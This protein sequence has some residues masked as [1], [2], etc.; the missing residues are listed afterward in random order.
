[1]ARL[2]SKDYHEKS[3]SWYFNH[4]VIPLENGDLEYW[5]SIDEKGYYHIHFVA[6]PDKKEF[7]NTQ[8]DVVYDPESQRIISHHCQECKDDESCRHYLSVLRYAYMNLRTDI[9]E[10][11]AVE[12]CD[13]TALRGKEKWLEV[14]SKAVLEIEGIYSPDT[15][16]V[17]FYHDSYEPLNISLL[18]RIQA[19]IDIEGITEQE[20]QELVSQLDIFSETEQALFKFLNEHKA[21][22]SS[23][24]KYW[25]LYKK[26]FISAL[27]FLQ[28]L[29]GKVKV[30]ETDE[31][32]KFSSE[33]YPLSLRIEPAGK[34]NYR[35]Y[36][37]IID[38]LSAVYPGYPTWLF[39]RNVVRPVYLPLS[40]ESINLLFN[41]ELLISAK[42]LIYWSTVV[43]KQLHK[44]GI[45]LDFDP[46]IELPEIIRT[47][48]RIK[49][50]VFPQGDNYI[51]EGKLVYLSPYLEESHKLEIPLSTIRFQ[52]PLIRSDYISDEENGNAWFYIPP[53]IFD[54]AKELY[55]KLPEANMSRLEQYSQLIYEGEKG[56]DKLRKS[57]FDLESPDWDLEIAAELRGDF[58]QKVD[59][60][61]EIKAKR[62]E[63]INWFSYEVSYYY[64]D[65]RFT[66]EELN[67]F[68]RSKEEF[69]HTKDGR[70]LY[71]VNPE[72]F[73]ESARLIKHS[74]RL[75]DNVYRAS[76]IELPYYHRYMREN[77]AFRML[78]DDFLTQL[79]IDL[80][81]GHMEHTEPLPLY[82]Q[83]VMRGYQKT[84]YAWIKM[85]E[86][87]HL[88]G[89]LADE[90]GLGKTIQALA[91][92]QNAP[93]NTQSLVVCP[94]TLL[95]NWAAEIDKFHINIPYLIVEGDK[96]TRI[97]LLQNPNVKLFIISYTVVLNDIDILKDKK[98]HWIILDEAQNIKNVNAKRTSAIKK[99]SAEHRL[100][101]TGTPVENNLTELWSIY[102]FLM[103]GYLGTLKRFKKE[104]IDDTENGPTRL[105]RTVAPFLLRRVKKEVLL[106]LPDKQEQVSWC[107]L[108]PVQEK[109]YLQMID[110]V[111]KKLLHGPEAAQLNF[112]NVLAALTKLRQICNHP[113]LADPDI[114]PKPEASAKLELLIELVEDAM[115]SGHKILVFSQ[116]VQMLKIIRQIFNDMNIKYAYM[117][118]RSKNRLKEVQRFENDPELQLFLI[119]LKTGGTGLNLTAADTVILYD[120]WW[121]PMVENQAIDRTHRIGQT[122]KVQVYRLI[123][124]GTVEEK[125]M[126]LQ[127]HK[128]QLFD[129]VV[130]DNKKLL[131]SLTP[132]E[133][134]DLFTY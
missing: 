18:M 47:E 4:V 103:P 6:T 82:L 11:P 88:G 45:Y 75:A 55:E 60:Q 94:K 8:L 81:R 40:N 65:L 121:N 49:F 41:Q 28:S 39:F 25:S 33:P 16:K 9:F 57:L 63:E 116:F 134:R 118:G 110:V 80:K 99:I 52:A 107:K 58:I 90:M 14:Y 66:Y 23:K 122:Q 120:P 87:Y 42:D 69:L 44:Q 71:I 20:K 53:H 27:S 51:L 15:D 37:V 1:M 64:K 77:P 3:A 113:H 106:E 22:Y 36:P 112:V 21:A 19:G 104:Y 129:E 24:T 96:D 48:P 2:F 38:E 108:H 72:V 67:R 10:Q 114:L 95:Y 74:E 32:L 100:A 97:Q 93:E 70:I 124:K 50:K 98:L 17:R 73:F 43:H 109:L 111:Q 130:S 26:D 76:L 85:L 30:R 128:L 35:V 115:G 59:L 12:T 54:Q 127:Q 61:V 102:D 125:I 91:A 84:G 92:I 56:L 5:Q 105:R 119:S 101:L 68:F 131:S 78:G 79:G 46:S 133:I 89:I 34:V 132:D 117:D 123:T 31:P 29:N 13:G 126:N 62:S 83:T 86:Y 7:F